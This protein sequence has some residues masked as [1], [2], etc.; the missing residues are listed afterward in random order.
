MPEKAAA[1]LKTIAA[2]HRKI[3]QVIDS[4]FC[5]LFSMLTVWEYVS[6]QYPS[7]VKY[8]QVPLHNKV[9]Q[10]Q[11]LPVDGALSLFCF[12]PA[13]FLLIGPPS[14]LTFASRWGREVWRK[15]SVVP[16]VS[17]REVLRWLGC[18]STV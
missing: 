17:K 11:V 16:Q 7:E 10:S 3:H 9:L 2:Y 15:V 8:Q 13:G 6:V 14:S 1:A 5:E 4:A 12:G 18:G